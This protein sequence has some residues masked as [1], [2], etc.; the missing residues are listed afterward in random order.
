MVTRRDGFLAA[1]DEA[2]AAAR[3][4]MAPPPGQGQQQRSQTA[5]ENVG[6]QLQRG[7]TGLEAGITVSGPRLQFLIWLT[8][9]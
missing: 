6:S 4:S 1:L 2:T 3:S 7:L 5:V 8:S 9:T